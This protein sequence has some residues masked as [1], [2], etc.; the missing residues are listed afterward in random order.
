MRKSTVRRLVPFATLLAVVT[1]V[2]SPTPGVLG[3]QSGALRAMVDGHPIP[4][5]EVSSLSCHDLAYPLIRCFH[6][7]PAM[8][9]DEMQAQAT[10]PAGPRIT[11]WVTWYRDA[12]YGGPAFDAA[13]SWPDLATINWRHQISSF[14]SY[15]GANP[16]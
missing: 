8:H 3:G 7:E 10:A 16:H 12:G 11:V 13:F 5:A 2:I 6:D 14:R 4:L 9:A 1:V 15:S